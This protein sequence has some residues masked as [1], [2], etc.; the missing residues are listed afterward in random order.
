MQK[1][2]RLLLFFVCRKQLVRGRWCY[3]AAMTKHD[4][5]RGIDILAKS[6]YRDLKQSGY[7]RADILAFASNILENI[8]ED[9]KASRA[10]QVE[11]AP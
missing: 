10:Q 11:S 3:T 9:A 2:P 6:V 7:S 8:T 1:T 4:A 5:E